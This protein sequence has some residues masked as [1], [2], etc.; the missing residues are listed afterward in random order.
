MVFASNVVIAVDGVS[1]I[2]VITEDDMLCP[3]QASLHSPP[4]ALH[5]SV[6]TSACCSH[7]LFFYAYSVVRRFIVPVCPFVHPKEVNIYLLSRGQEAQV[8]YGITGVAVCEQLS[9]FD[10]I[11]S[12]WM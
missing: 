11:A 5:Y 9:C 1:S 10:K 12:I 2:A 7:R 6:L 4:G 3:R 8:M